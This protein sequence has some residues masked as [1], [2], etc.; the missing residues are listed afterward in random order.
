VDGTR[1]A[2]TLR[3]ILSLASDAIGVATGIYFVVHFLTSRAANARDT[4]IQA[5][6]S[7]VEL[8]PPKERSIGNKIIDGVRSELEKP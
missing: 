6:R 2:G 8:L 4:A 7:D 1:D 3:E 5:L